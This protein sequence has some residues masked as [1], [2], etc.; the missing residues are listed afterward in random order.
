[1]M[2]MKKRIL[3]A[4]LVCAMLTA[5][6]V[7]CSDSKTNA[8]ETTGT[9]SA[10]PSV[11][12]VEETEPEETEPEFLPDELPADLD[13]GGETVNIFC[14]NSWDPG[15]LFVEEDNG[16]LAVSAVFNRNLTVEDRL[17]VKL[18]FDERE[19]NS[20]AYGSA[21]K[22]AVHQQN[23]SGD[24]AYDLVSCY[25]MRVAS[26]AVEGQLTNLCD[27][28]YIDLTKPWY[29]ESAVEAGTLLKNHSYLF[30]GDISFNALARMSGVFFNRGL[31]T[32]YNLED[33]YTLV[34][35]GKWT[36]DKLSEMINGLFVDVNNDAK[37]DN[38][39]Y[40]GL[41]IAG[42]QMQTLYYGTGSH[43]IEHDAN[44]SPVLSEDISSERTLSILEKY[45]SVF[46]KQDAYKNPIGDDPTI[47]DTGRTLFYIYPLGHV[48]D[49]SL[50]ESEV[51]YGFIPQPKVEEA[52]ENYHA[53]VTNAV[54]LFAIPLVVK[55]LDV[56]SAVAECMS[57]EGHR[58]VTPVIF[59]QA[60]K[61]K[62][63]Q[64][65]SQRQ[66][67]IF[68]MLRE[69]AVFDLGKIFADTFGGFS[70][71][72]IGDTIWNGNNTYASSLKGRMKALTKS[73]EKLTKNLN[74][75][76]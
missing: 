13:F 35:E 58:Q 21:L 40:Y 75:E 7:S 63:N 60:Y 56:S 33:P 29:Y 25:G 34:L 44:G 67:V 36:I 4:L 19:R 74:L 52:D 14:W 28:Q 45:L 69:N 3:S 53:S 66:S 17:N 43:F 31:I 38:D 46:E 62:Y 64:D 65:D 76:P 10:E 70:N 30:A 22:D 61:V 49:P 32:D 42:D 6:F 57:S 59:E 2:N 47:F 72:V 16:D 48:S 51:D 39:D 37:Q 15:E 20:A 8:D 41:M 24:A 5:S 54:S 55:S 73:M 1:M 27:T 26:L 18:V 68:D 50:R 23:S 9:A 12:E 11:S 71:G